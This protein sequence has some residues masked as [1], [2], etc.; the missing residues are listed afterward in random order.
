MINN[1]KNFNIVLSSNLQ[2]RFDSCEFV[3][4]F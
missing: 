3:N 1:I 4:L 2:H